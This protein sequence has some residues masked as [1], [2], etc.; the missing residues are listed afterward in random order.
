MLGNM[1][2]IKKMQAEMAKIQ[3]DLRSRTVD[4]TA[5]GGAV[6]ATVNGHKELVG[7]KIDPAAVDPQDMSMLEDMIIAA[8][9]EGQ[10]MAEEMAAKAMGALIPGGLKIPGLF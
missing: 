5:G 4:A 2:M 3:E 8:V 1:Q 7:I 10:H 6:T 9:K